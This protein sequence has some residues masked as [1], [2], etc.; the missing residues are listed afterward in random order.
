M[1]RIFF[2]FLF[3]PLLLPSACSFPPIPRYYQV[4]LP[5]LP[6]P[7]G[8][9]LGKPLWRLE[10]INGEGREEVYEG[11]EMGFPELSLIQ[12]WSSP[13]I[14]W[15]YWP[16][17][18]LF[19][20]DMKPAGAI[21]PW[22]VSGSRVILGWNAGVDAFFWRKLASG[23]TGNSTRVPWYFD[24]PR[25]RELFQGTVLDEAVRL[26]P[27]RVDWEVLARKTLESG[28]YRSRIVPRPVTE[29]TIPGL[30]SFWIGSSPFSQPLDFPSGDSLILPAGEAVETW[31]SP[32]GI[33]RCNRDTWFFSQ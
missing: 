30:G 33:L 14:A 21:F 12:E 27:W 11:P 6:A 32:E 10:W 15:P 19:P 18:K 2:A 20:G 1:K 8:G 4:S 7:W 23:A 31:V 16:E 3:F 13:I 9:L 24:W 5:F 29:L 25:F 28:F 17:K 26:D 22:D